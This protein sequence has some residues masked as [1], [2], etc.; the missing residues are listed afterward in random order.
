[1][2]ESIPFR[3]GTIPIKTIPKGTLLFRLVK[4]P[5]NDTRGI[6]TEEGERCMHP[7][8]NV[9]FY[10]NPFNAKIALDLWVTK[11]KDMRVYILTK[12]V[13][14][15]NLTSP[16]KY[17]RTYKNKKGRFIKRCSRVPKGCL[18]RAMNHYDPCV[19]K[20]VIEKHPEV[21]GMITI[22]HADAVRAQQGLKRK[23]MRNKLKYF[24]FA[25]D[26]DGN[27]AVPE[28]V[29]HPLS[30]RPS[31]EFLVKDSDT[32]KNSYKLLKSFKT[33]DEK[34]LMNFMDKHAVYNPDSFFYT[35]KE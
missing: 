18:P 19:S 20:S 14:V 15:I 10:P 22:P 35:Y 12:D 30:P 8:F 9:Y 16:S 25:K 1:M 4:D 27:E 5:K 13:R 28:L 24:K 34:S 17:S 33:D 32:L 7:N 3:R 26:S 21:T 31:K 6:P 2:E 29:L 11:L 23:T